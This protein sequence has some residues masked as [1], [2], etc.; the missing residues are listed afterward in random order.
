MIHPAAWFG[1]AGAI[2]VI[3]SSTRNPWYLGL[4]LAWIGVVGMVAHTSITRAAP[5]PISPLR[6]G[7][8][9]ITFS[10]LFNALTVHVGRTVLFTIPDFIPFL[11]GPVTLEALV[12]G[13][14]NGLVLTGMFAAFTVINR[15]LSVRQMI[16][17]VP[18]A[19][20]P[21]AVI[22]SIA[23]TF[24]PFTLRQFRQIREA[25]M[26]RGHRV[27]GVRDWLPLIMPLLVGGLERALQLAE[28]M[29]ARGFAGSDASA[30][31][32]GTKSMMILGLL[33][34]LAGWLLQRVW[35]Q[36]AWGWILLLVGV[37]LIIGSLWLVGRRVPRTTYRPQ[38][39]RFSDWGILVCAGMAMLAFI[40]PWPGLDRVSIFY[41]P[42]PAISLPEFNLFLSG[43]TV[44]LV[45]PALILRQIPIRYF[46]RGSSSLEPERAR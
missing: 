26:V 10:A 39:W 36:I 21:V 17:L 8:F 16:R 5:I 44:G 22:V 41:Y 29:T 24:V 20:F 1:W 31:D 33:L 46:R 2:V 40:V 42:Y 13:A 28:A 9:V 35:G 32:V 3:L 34:V 43:A 15:M 27:Q 14:L 37:V 45:V 18:H 30:H 4:V 6:F 11:G 19:F 38:P 25:Q 7:F 23:I 12:Y